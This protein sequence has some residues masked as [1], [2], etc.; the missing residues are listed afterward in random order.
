MFP[1]NIATLSAMLLLR[2]TFRF[3]LS[4]KMSNPE[5]ILNVIPRD[6]KIQV[7]QGMPSHTRAP[8]PQLN[9]KKANT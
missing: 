3:D 8:G 9:I 5:G 2:N 1:S 4:R 6:K 7:A